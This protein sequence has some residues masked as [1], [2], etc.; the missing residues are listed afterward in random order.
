MAKLTEAYLKNLIKKV[1]KES[2]VESPRKKLLDYLE[3][4]INEKDVKAVVAVLDRKVEEAKETGK[5]FTSEDITFNLGY[6]ILDALPDDGSLHGMLNAVLDDE[7]SATAYAD[8]EAD[9]KDVKATQRGL[10][11]ESRKASGGGYK[12]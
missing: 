4:H 3:S 5:M 9:R 11:T 8:A 12:R 2:M 6:N 10:M 1:M 7:F